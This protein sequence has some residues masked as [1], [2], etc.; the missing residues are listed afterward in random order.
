MSTRLQPSHGA[1]SDAL[2][3]VILVMAAPFFS[4]RNH[5]DPMTDGLRS[6]LHATP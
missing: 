3:A 6:T 2:R 4:T 5:I 1:H